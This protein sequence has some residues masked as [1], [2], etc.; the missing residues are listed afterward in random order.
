MATRSK[1]TAE[2]RRKE[3]ARK[4]KQRSKLERRA[5]RKLDPSLPEEEEE[6]V[7]EVR[8]E[9]EYVLGTGLVLVERTEP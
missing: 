5:Q 6:V 3:M 2:K 7:T 4:E 9:E 1:A 8:L